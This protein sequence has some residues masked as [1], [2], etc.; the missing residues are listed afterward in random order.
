[1]KKRFETLNGVYEGFIKDN[2]INGMYD[3]NDRDTL[4]K[5]LNAQ[6]ERIEN[7]LSKL[8]ASNSQLAS[9]ELEYNKLKLSFYQQEKLL[10][11]KLACNSRFHLAVFSSFYRFL[12]EII[13]FYRFLSVVIA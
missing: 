5:L 9:F 2:E 4:V 8:R 1:M 3:E 13:A 6:Y 12:A 7:L 10:S 11:E